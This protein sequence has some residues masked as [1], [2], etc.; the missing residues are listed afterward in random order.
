MKVARIARGSVR[1][2]SGSSGSEKKNMIA[3]LKMIASS[4]KSRFRASPENARYQCS[5][6]NAATKQVQKGV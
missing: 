4:V 3:K 6:Q 5:K 2:G 1:I